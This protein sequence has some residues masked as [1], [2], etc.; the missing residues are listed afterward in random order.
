VHLNLTF[1][2]YKSFTYDTKRGNVHP[3]PSLALL[4]GD[5]PW[6]FTVRVRPDAGHPPG[7]TFFTIQDVLLAIY[8]HL[9]TAVKGDEY[10]AVSKSG[11]AEIFQAIESRVDTDLIQ[12]GKGLRRVD[13]LGGQELLRAQSKDSQHMGRRHL[14]IDAASPNAAARQSP[15]MKNNVVCFTKA[16]RSQELLDREVR[17][18]Y[19]FAREN[20]IFIIDDGKE[21]GAGRQNRVRW[22]LQAPILD[23]ILE[24]VLP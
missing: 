2:F 16:G 13:I 14:L 5:P 9:R 23:E 17:E 4:V 21:T 20:I 8:F 22:I 18:L 24:L 12:R 7:N 19:D 3:L 10:E 1:S 11:K 15:I 6:L